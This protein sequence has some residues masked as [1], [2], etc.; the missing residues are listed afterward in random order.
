MERAWADNR[1]Q[2]APAHS[3]GLAGQPS[4]IKRYSI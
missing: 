1:N 4:G 3:S 2:I